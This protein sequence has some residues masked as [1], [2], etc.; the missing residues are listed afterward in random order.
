[1]AEEKKEKIPPL[2]KI[3]A[4]PLGIF[5]IIIALP[6]ALIISRPFR[7]HK[8]RKTD[9][10]LAL[11]KKCFNSKFAPKEFKAHYLFNMGIIERERGLIEDAITHFSQAKAMGCE[12]DPEKHTTGPVMPK[13]KKSGG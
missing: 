6:K 1:M 10:A 4:I 7:K 8:E 13:P 11:Y 9:E 2:M 3:I 12:E 5:F